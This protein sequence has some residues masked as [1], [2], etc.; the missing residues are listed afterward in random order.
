[1]SDD[2]SVQCADRYAFDIVWLTIWHVALSENNF[3]TD[4]CNSARYWSE[5]WPVGTK[6][7]SWCALLWLSHCWDRLLPSV[8]YATFSYF[9]PCL[10]TKNAD[11][12][13]SCDVSCQRIYCHLANVQIAS[14]QEM[15][16][17]MTDWWSWIASNNRQ[18]LRDSLMME[19][20]L[21]ILGKA[22]KFTTTKNVFF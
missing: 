22:R 1:M 17:V 21:T 14:S 5:C 11:C 7:S 10:M 19:L 6:G 16:L 2:C 15:C 3:R 9:C 4:E 18:T 12:Y 8:I 20:S 13:P